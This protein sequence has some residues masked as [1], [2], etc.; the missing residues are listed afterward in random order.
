MYTATGLFVAPGRLPWVRQVAWVGN[1]VW[2]PS[3]A[4]TALMLLPFL[5]GR[6]PSPRWRPVAWTVGVAGGLTLIGA[7]CR[8][9][10]LDVA[11]LVE[12]AE[13]TAQ[14]TNPLGVAALGQLF[15]PFL[16]VLLLGE[17]VGAAALLLR[18]RRSRG[19]ERQQLKWIAYAALL[20]GIQQGGLA[21]ARL[22]GVVPDT[23]M[24][25]PE[26][27]DTFTFV[28]SFVA[29]AVAV[30]RYRL[31]EIDRLINRTLVYVL[32]TVL[33]G[34]VYTAGV[35][36]LGRLLNPVTGQAT[37]AVAASTLAV[38][39]LFQPVRRRIQAAVDRR[40]NRRRYDAA[41][42]VEAF[43]ARLRD[44]VDLDTLS[45]PT[46]GQGHVLSLTALFE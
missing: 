38:T 24:A 30:L 42:T 37:L 19:I 35:F 13:V 4:C 22:A 7:A 5:V 18:F 20:F 1:W 10:L 2:V 44:Q 3:H 17:A 27:V 45:S 41:K 46:P 23:E 36:G 8:P 33:L 9:A 15:E 28:F 16:L 21:L 29:I 11:F 14:L 40:F 12:D 39:A 6:L 43:S 34:A 31:Y 25:W 32:V 26:V